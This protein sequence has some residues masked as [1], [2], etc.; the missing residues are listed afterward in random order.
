MKVK[1]LC[2]LLSI[3][4]Q[5]SALQAAQDNTKI[6]HVIVNDYLQQAKERAIAQERKANHLLDDIGFSKSSTCI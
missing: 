5:S 2:L 1:L 4:L 6:K 3:I